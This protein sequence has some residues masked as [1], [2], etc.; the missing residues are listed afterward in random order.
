MWRDQHHLF[1]ARLGQKFRAV[2]FL[3]ADNTRLLKLFPVPPEQSNE[4]WARQYGVRS[5]LYQSFPRDWRLP[6]YLHPEGHCLR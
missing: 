1:S 5:V 2:C 4:T 3:G 6:L